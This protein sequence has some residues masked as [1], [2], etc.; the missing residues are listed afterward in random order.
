MLIALVTLIPYSIAAEDQ[1]PSERVREP[2]GQIIEHEGTKYKAFTLEEWK[3]MA[4]LILDY[5]VIWDYSLNLELE[6]DSL[7]REAKLWEQRVDIWKSATDEQR[8]R[9]DILSKL[10]DEEHKMRLKLEKQYRTLGWVPWTL[11]VVESIAF[12]IV[13]V[14]SGVKLAAAN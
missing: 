3:Q 6:I 5:H 10:F 1:R 14:Y 12:G 8:A 2:I 11:V 9:G 7:K 4:H 13:G